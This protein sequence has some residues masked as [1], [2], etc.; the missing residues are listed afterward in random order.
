MLPDAVSRRM[1]ERLLPVV[2]ALENRKII[3]QMHPDLALIARI[4][5]AL[6]GKF[7]LVHGQ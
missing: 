6:L 4:L 7:L 5:H 1:P 2:H 3:H